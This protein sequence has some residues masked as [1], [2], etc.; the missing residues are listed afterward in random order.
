METEEEEAAFS[1]THEAMEPRIVRPR[2]C[3]QS[4]A[5]P[6][7]PDRMPDSSSRLTQTTWAHTENGQIAYV[8]SLS[9]M[10]WWLWM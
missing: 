8:T 9:P 2:K 5:I 1:R 4:A 3:Q 10:I 7:T 6:T